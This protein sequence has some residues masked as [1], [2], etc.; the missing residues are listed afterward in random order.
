M[1]AGGAREIAHL[2]S[3]IGETQPG[4]AGGA[5]R[6]AHPGHFADITKDVAKSYKLSVENEPIEIEPY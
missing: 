3:F 2:R 5:P 1:T 6:P 4:I